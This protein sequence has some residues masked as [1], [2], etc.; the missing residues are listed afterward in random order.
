M[1]RVFLANSNFGM[2]EYI[3]ITTMILNDWNEFR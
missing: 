1:N 3:F 2:E